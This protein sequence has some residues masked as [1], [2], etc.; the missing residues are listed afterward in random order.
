MDPPKHY[1]FLFGASGPGKPMNILNKVFDLPS[2][3][4]LWTP[5]I[6]L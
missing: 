4:F 3:V 2:P 5:P 1:G 6:F